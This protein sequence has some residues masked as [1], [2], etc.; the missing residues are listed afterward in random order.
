MKT[1]TRFR[2][3]R[4]FELLNLFQ[5]ALVPVYAFVSVFSMLVMILLISF[6]MYGSGLAGWFG[7]YVI[8]TMSMAYEFQDAGKSW[9]ET[10]RIFKEMM[11][12]E[13]RATISVTSF[14][15]IKHATQKSELFM[16][17]G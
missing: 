2:I 16:K 9:E 17:R 3:H 10:D 8:C 12:I 7:I 14:N 13:M 6:D 15:D 11:E 5:R 1:K 4:L